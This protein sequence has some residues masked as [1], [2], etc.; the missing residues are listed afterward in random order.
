MALKT[1]LTV[2]SQYSHIGTSLTVPINPVCVSVLSEH[3]VLH[4]IPSITLGYESKPI[5]K[6]WAAAVPALVPLKVI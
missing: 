3:W 6:L 5:S 4:W 1:R 2:V